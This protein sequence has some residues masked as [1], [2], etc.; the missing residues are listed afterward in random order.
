MIVKLNGEALTSDGRAFGFDPTG[1][2]VFARVYDDISE[3]HLGCRLTVHDSR[4]GRTLAR[5]KVEGRV[6][7]LAPGGKLIAD[8]T[9]TELVL[10][11]LPGGQVKAR[12]PAV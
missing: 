6:H 7:D 5:T 2:T 11:R 4:N 9:E 3:D 8:V 12:Q 1:S 10:R